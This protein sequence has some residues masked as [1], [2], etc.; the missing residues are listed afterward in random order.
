[1]SETICISS[2]VS[3]KKIQLL[4]SSCC[5]TS[6]AIVRNARDIILQWR[7]QKHKSYISLYPVCNTEIHTQLTSCNIWNR[8]QNIYISLHNTSSHAHLLHHHTNTHP[9]QLTFVTHISVSSLRYSH[10]NWWHFI[11]LCYPQSGVFF[12][13]HIKIFFLQHNTVIQLTAVLH[14]LFWNSK[15]ISSVTPYFSV[16]RINGNIFFAA[17]T[18]KHTKQIAA[19]PH[20][21]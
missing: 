21:R 11:T 13:T 3:V 8:Q 1:M 19:I 7:G 10:S 6:L 18:V 9:R 4:L 14:I 20:K 5:C 2:T 12:Y 17:N 15:A 16:H